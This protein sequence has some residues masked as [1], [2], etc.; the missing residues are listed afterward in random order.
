MRQLAILLRVEADDMPQTV[1]ALK[2]EIAGFK[3]VRT[4]CEGSVH[5]WVH[6]PEMIIDGMTGYQSIRCGCG[7]MPESTRRDLH[8]APTDQPAPLLWMTMQAFKEH[9]A[10]VTQ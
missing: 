2:A 6:R 3:P 8:F 1:E 5:D 10:K 9:V 7:W 4:K